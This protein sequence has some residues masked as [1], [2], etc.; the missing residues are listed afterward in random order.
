MQFEIEKDYE[1]FNNVE[2]IKEFVEIYKRGWLLTK[3]DEFSI[4]VPDHL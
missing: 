3:E 1:N 4:Y 2:E